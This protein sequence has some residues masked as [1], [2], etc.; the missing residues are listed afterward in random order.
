MEENKNEQELNITSE[1][2]AKNTSSEP[3]LESNAARRMRLLGIENDSKIHD[4]S[5]EITK[6]S[7][8][9][10]LWYKRKWTIIISAF[11]IILAIVLACTLIFKN[12]PDL[13]IGYIGPIEL[14][15]SDKANINDVFT[16]YM[17]NYDGDKKKELVINT[18]LYR[19][20]E[21][22]N[23]YG[24][25]SNA[26]IEN[27]N[28]EALN[29]FYDDIRY[30]NYKMVLI[31][32]SLYDRYEKEFCTINE[33]KEM[34]ANLD[35]LDEGFFYKERGIIL[36]Y[37]K[38]AIDNRAELG[39]ILKEKVIICFCKPNVVGKK[40]D[41]EITFLNSILANESKENQ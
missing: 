30:N 3:V 28:N 8:W 37:T 1:Q 21:Q 25:G 19:T 38:L 13:T 16:S 4:T 34:G 27:A 11:F 32:E 24:K 23:K 10:N 33:L 35:G 26:T 40:L 29:S 36:N 12:D 15:K 2:E 6:G 14:T 7:F 9:G 22:Q 31:D 5:E 39:D 20:K 18:T 17:D 41:N